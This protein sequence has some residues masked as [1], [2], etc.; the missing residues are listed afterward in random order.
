[1][2]RV[3]NEQQSLLKLLTL[4]VKFGYKHSIVHAKKRLEVSLRKK[5]VLLFPFPRDRIA[6]YQLVKGGELFAE[7]QIFYP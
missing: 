4:F 2:S 5:K 7:H 1:L 6:K 3:V